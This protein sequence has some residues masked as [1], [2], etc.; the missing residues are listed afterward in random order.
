MTDSRYSSLTPVRPRPL[1][2]DA[3]ELKAEVLR[4]RDEIIG[5]RAVIAEA[6]VRDKAR[7]ES[8]ALSAVI[9]PSAHVVYLQGVVADLEF[10]LREVRSS[11]TWKVGRVLLSPVWALRSLFRPSGSRAGDQA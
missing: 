9:D 10:Q 1:P 5:L 6:E 4:L 3:R 11:S 7:A 8:E 2:D